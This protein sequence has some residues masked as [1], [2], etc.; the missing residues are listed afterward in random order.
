MGEKLGTAPKIGLLIDFD[1]DG[2]M[3]QNVK[4]LTITLIEI[5]N[6]VFV[7]MLWQNMDT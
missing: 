2:N 5:L 6:Q 3:N 4:I 1:V 7:K